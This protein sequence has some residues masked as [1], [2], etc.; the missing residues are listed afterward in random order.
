VKS[1]RKTIQEARLLSV[2]KDNK[3]KILTSFVEDNKAFFVCKCKNKT[4]PTF[5]HR[6]Y[7]LSIG[8]WCKECFYEQRRNK[9][10]HIK[11]TKEE[12][13]IIEGTI[14]GDASISK[15]SDAFNYHLKIKH[16]DAQFEYLD[17]F[18]QKLQK[19]N[20]YFGKIEKQ[21]NSPLNIDGT[22]K[23]MFKKW[24]I[25]KALHTMSCV[26]I[27][28]LEKKWYDKNRIKHIPKD[29]KLTN[30]SAAI[31]YLDDGCNEGS[32]KTHKFNQLYFATD[33]F[34]ENDIDRLVGMLIKLGYDNIQKFTHKGKWRIKIKGKSYRKFLNMVKR[35]ISPFPKCFN[36][37]INTSECPP[38]RHEMVGK[39]G[40]KYVIFN[41]KT[42][43]NKYHIR[44]TLNHKDSIYIS[45]TNNYLNAKFISKQLQQM[46]ANNATHQDYLNYRTE[47]AASK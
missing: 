44:I 12:T 15:A 46:K 1:I 47:L 30:L 14:L 6:Y 39:T 31:W 2:V 33:C 38:F 26:A 19:L 24:I 29:F 11:L 45:S 43:K 13:Q 18:Y 16:S 36:Y 20:P 5:V 7:D 28:N 4:H 32:T 22:A 25:S 21:K 9:T 3:G 42:A 27:T 17:W 40:V 34:T 35:V 8:R 10:A 23:K 37:K 41:K